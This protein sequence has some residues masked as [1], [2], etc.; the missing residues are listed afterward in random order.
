MG[1]FGRRYMG[2]LVTRASGVPL[3]RGLMCAAL[4]S[5]VLPF[6]SAP[7][8]AQKWA[9][10][11]EAI[12]QVQHELKQVLPPAEQP[13]TQDQSIA[14]QDSR[15]PTPESLAAAGLEPPQSGAAGALN[16]ALNLQALGNET[17]CM[18]AVEKARS[19]AGL[20]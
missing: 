4:V 3:I 7:A 1:D 15:E 9:T 13:K 17:G 14:A 6:A 12:A 5:A 16:E 18:E 8:H 2:T 19:L 20:K 10:C 11:L